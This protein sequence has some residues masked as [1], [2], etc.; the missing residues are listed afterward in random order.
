MAQLPMYPAVVNSPGTE[1][2]AAISASDTT[3]SLVSVTGIPAAPNL[4]TIGSDETAETIRYTAINE[5]TLTVE[6]A[7]QSVAKSWSAGAKVA[8]YFTAYDYDAMRQNIAETFT[9]VSSGKTEVAAAITDMGQS[10]G[11][12]A[13]FA[14]MATNVRN[15]SKDATAT[16]ADLRAGKTMYSGGAKKTGSL[17]VQA[18]GAQTITPGPTDIV[19]SAGIYDGPITVK[20]VPVDSN[21]VLVGNSIAGTAGAMPNRS[22]ENYHMPGAAA[23]LASGD[24]IFIKPIWGYY[25]GQSWVSYPIP[26]LRPENLR[27]GIQ[28]LNMTGILI[29]GK[30]FATGKYTGSNI[31]VAGLSFPPNR[32]LVWGSYGDSSYYMDNFLQAKRHYYFGSTPSVSLFS[33]FGYVANGFT[34]ST[35]ENSNIEWSWEAYA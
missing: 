29:E 4:L 1:L 17:P 21:T 7:F 13:E 10:T 19:K 24:R 2:A 6:R 16:A 28:V 9:S 27:D 30:K 34:C 22:A 23:E 12:T 33:G 18:T 11:S 20:G 32:I 26:N 35:N 14:V 25:D 31:H 15:I 5:K 3:I 8:R